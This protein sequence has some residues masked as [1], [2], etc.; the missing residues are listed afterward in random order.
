MLLYRLLVERAY[1]PRV[2]LS[3]APLGGVVNNL[4]RALQEGRLDSR[5]SSVYQEGP[6]PRGHRAAHH[7]TL[8]VHTDMRG[9]MLLLSSDKSS[10]V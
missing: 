7:H 6:P 2:D 9:S 4:A 5:R 1:N 8:R 10:F 3:Q